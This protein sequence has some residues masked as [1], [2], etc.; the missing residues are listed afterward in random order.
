[1]GRVPGGTDRQYNRLQR[2]GAFDYEDGE[3]IV[4]VLSGGNIDLNL[5][6]TVLI[7]GLVETGRY[8][9]LRTV[10]KDRPGALQGLTD[11]LAAHR[12]NI[13][14]IRHE[15][16]ARDVA[17]DD[18]EVELDLETRGPEHVAELLDAL[19]AHGYETEILV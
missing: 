13:Y 8:L 12:A 17:M 11:V 18:A 19:E 4:P 3:V 6:T 2:T 15:R 14:A 5:L 7:R 10:L 16:T 9:R 1:M